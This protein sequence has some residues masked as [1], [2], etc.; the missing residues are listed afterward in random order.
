[1]IMETIPTAAMVVVMGILNM[2]P[3]MSSISRLP[4][5][6]SIVPTHRNSRALVTAWKTRMISAAEYAS[7]EPMP[8]QATI[9]PRLAMVE[10]ASTRFPLLWLIAIAEV[11]ANV[12]APA[13]AMTVASLVSANAGASRRMR[14][15]PALTI[16]LE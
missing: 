11:T 13:S 4:M 3:L 7:G 9:S 8:A 12:N 15:E 6:C 10:Y 1:M 14:Y 16:V 2:M 5:V